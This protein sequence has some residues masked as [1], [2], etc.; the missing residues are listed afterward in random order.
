MT[1]AEYRWRGARL[2]LEGMEDRQDRKMLIEMNGGRCGLKQFGILVRGYG[3]AR[4]YRNKPSGRALRGVSLRSREALL[5]LFRP[6]ALRESRTEASFV[7]P[8]G[9]LRR[10]RPGNH[11]MEEQR[12]IENIHRRDKWANPLIDL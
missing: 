12:A 10:R 5:P 6:V 1:E 11:R 2:V 4:M 9:K 8:S 7:R 3:A